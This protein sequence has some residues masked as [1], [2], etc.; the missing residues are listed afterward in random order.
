MKKIEKQGENN[1]KAL[2]YAAVAAGKRKSGQETEVK[3]Q[4]LNEEN[5][6]T[7]KRKMKGIIVRIED[8]KEQEALGKKTTKKIVDAL[9]VSNEEVTGI[10]RLPSGDLK[11]H[12]KTPEVKETLQ[13]HSE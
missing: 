8:P 10:R 4:G 2:S 6:H 5:T 12:V 3:N 7:E 11:I 1:G 9:R 13:A